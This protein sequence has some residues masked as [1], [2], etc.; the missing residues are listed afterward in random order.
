[1]TRSFSLSLSL[2]LC[3]T[4]SNFT[5]NWHLTDVVQRQTLL[6]SNAWPKDE[7]QRRSSGR[8]SLLLLLVLRWSLS[9]FEARSSSF[10]LLQSFDEIH[11]GSVRI[12]GRD[13]KDFDRRWLREQI[14]VVSEEPV[15]FHLTIRENLCLGRLTA[16]DEEIESAAK[17]A[18]AHEV[19]LR[20][21]EVSGQNHSS[22][23]ISWSTLRNTK[24]AWEIAVLHSQEDRN[25][26]SVGF[27]PFSS[28][29]V[30][31]SSLL[32]LLL[33]PSLEL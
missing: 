29:R 11:S 22:S 17:M 10:Q 26:E 3:P 2:S 20:L 1:M 9:H 7:Q 28:S 19:I 8:R 13:V 12:A 31:R 15:L 5:S 18:N 16:T 14:G 23:R 33:Q 24:D 4:A 30:I 25:R 27:S 21:P 6:T 32:L